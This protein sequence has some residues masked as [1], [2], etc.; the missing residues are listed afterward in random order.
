MEF[1]FP[2]A[3]TTE[4]EDSGSNSAKE[5]RKKKTGRKDNGKKGKRSEK[6]NWLETRNKQSFTETKPKQKM[7]KGERCGQN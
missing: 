2:P 7:G 6:K 5:I 3:I 4:I 1:S